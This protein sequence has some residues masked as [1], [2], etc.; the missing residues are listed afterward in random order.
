M[1]TYHPTHTEVDCF[2]N[3]FGSF[4]RHKGSRGGFPFFF[5]DVHLFFR[6][7]EPHKEL[8]G[9]GNSYTHADSKK[10]KPSSLF[11]EL[12]LDLL[13]LILTDW[14]YSDLRTV[15]SVSQ[16]FDQLIWHFFIKK[17]TFSKPGL[18][19]RRFHHYTKKAVCCTSISISSGSEITDM[20][21]T[22][23]QM[24]NPSLL[25]TFE[26]CCPK[27]SDI[28]LNSISQFNSLKTLNIQRCC[29]ISDEGLIAI[30]N[31]TLLETLCLPSSITNT[32]LKHL[33]L[34]VNL[35]YLGVSE[36]FLIDEE[37]LKHFSHLSKTNIDFG[38]VDMKKFK[39]YKI[40][41][42]T[43]SNMHAQTKVGS[44]YQKGLGTIMDHTK[45]LM[46][47]TIAAEQGCGLAMNSIGW[48]HQNGLGVPKNDTEAI[49]WYIK[50]AEKG[51][52][53]GQNNLGFMYQH[54]RGILQDYE[55]AIYYFHLS[56]SSLNSNAVNNLGFMYQ[57]G[58]GVEK[59][60]E[61]SKM[62]YQKASIAGNTSATENLKYIQKLIIQE[63]A[64]LSV[65][66]K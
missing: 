13:K 24:E 56:A 33:K 31:L 58:L 29:K 38:E 27:I 21:L 1:Y 64:N 51:D 2:I 14:S 62:F 36:C 3:Q 37:G 42:D 63:K 57:K 4:Q 28:G 30:A 55:K 18:I 35:Q 60:L 43:Q 39:L 65:K 48:Y 32:G 12:P 45:A 15:Q 17:M 19:N 44:S 54:G 34:L 52:H 16:K 46:Y 20:A 8:D 9:M 22:G 25:Q 50:S 11:E 23:M 66:K 53:N 49:R 61:M 47:Y 59:N 7:T 41:A 5:Q 40:I 6:I 10:T 26:L